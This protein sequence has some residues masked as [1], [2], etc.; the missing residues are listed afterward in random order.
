M[1][2]YK[3]VCIILLILIGIPSLSLLQDA[4]A[5]DVYPPGITSL[6]GGSHP[7][8]ACDY[9]HSVLIPDR[10]ER[11][12]V[13]GSCI[14]HKDTYSPSGKVDMELV[15]EGHDGNPCSRCHTGVK[16]EKLDVDNYHLLH[17]DVE[18]T[19]CHEKSN[20]GFTIPEMKCDDCHIGG[21]HV[22]HG[23]KAESLCSACHG[24]YGEQFKSKGVSTAV[25]GGNMSAESTQHQHLTILGILKNLVGRYVN[26]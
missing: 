12:A 19:R 11:N 2:A 24:A 4:G 23:N 1:K 18:C 25:P 10:S 3:I 13:L 22:V 14:C 7:T 17:E 20:V 21:P 9:C 15:S 8:Q 26:I 5:K 6:L 16:L